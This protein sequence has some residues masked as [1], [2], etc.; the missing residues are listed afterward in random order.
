MSQSFGVGPVPT[1]PNQFFPLAMELQ[2]R[3]VERTALSTCRIYRWGTY[4][5]YFYIYVIMSI[6]TYRAHKITNTV[7]RDK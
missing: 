1:I 6:Y 3:I 5:Y 4:V 7:F 2:T